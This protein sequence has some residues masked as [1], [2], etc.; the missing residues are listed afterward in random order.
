VIVDARVYV[1]TS[2]LAAY[3]CPEPLSTTVEARLTNGSAL[4][5]SRLVQAELVSTIA[6]KVRTA[7]MTQEDARAALHVHDAQ[8]S[9][10]VFG[11]VT[12][13]DADLRVAISWMKRLD[14][15][16]RTLDGLHLAIADREELTLLTADTRFAAAARSLGKSV[17]LLNTS[18]TSSTEH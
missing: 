2:V 18:P 8:V 6:R 14:T 10:G 4:V 15:S 5:L 13:R 12:L 17:E 11:L 7:N 16:L 1:D 3:Y 9:D